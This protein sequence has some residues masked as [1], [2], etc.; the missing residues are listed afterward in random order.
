MVL[1]S[2]FPDER[3][4]TIT[5]FDYFDLAEGTGIEVYD[6]MVISDQTGIAPHSTQVIKYI[7][8]Q[9]S[10][11]SDGVEK[12]KS[13]STTA[14]D[15]A[16]DI[17]LDLSAFNLP[18]DIKG[19]ALVTFNG[20]MTGGDGAINHSASFEF[21]L[22]KWDGSSETLLGTGYSNPLG[23]VT[24]GTNTFYGATEI[25]ILTE[26]HFKRGD[27]LRLTVI[28]YTRSSNA[29]QG[30]TVKLDIDPVTAGE[31]L[32]LYIPFVIDT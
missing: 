25:P 8:H 5:S 11:E 9:D 29:G 24:I 2:I 1:S 15:E 10:I 27:V 28:A 13:G 14:D 18:K 6:G 17:D 7:L 16:F 12:S 20:S 23:T 3:P 30:G 32:K 19:T 22:Y 21:K 31:E 4:R 26:V